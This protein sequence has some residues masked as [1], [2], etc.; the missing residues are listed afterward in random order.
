MD[1]IRSFRPTR[2]LLA[3]F[4]KKEEEAAEYEP[5]TADTSFINDPSTDLDDSTEPTF[6]W[7]EY[8]IF[9]LL[10]VAM[11]WAWNMFLAAQP[12]FQ[13][14][15]QADPWVQDN[16]MSAILT[17]STFT[18][19]GAM[20]ILSNIQYSASYPFRINLALYINVAAFALLALSTRIFLDLA[21]AAYLTFILI[22][23]GSTAY[24]AGLIQNGA[25][26]FAASF[27]RSE[28]T[29]AIMAGQ[30][31][32]GVLPP[33]VQVISVLVAPPADTS[34]HASAAD[35]DEGKAAFLY[36][37][38]AVV[39]SLVALVAFVPLVRRHDQLVEN[40]MAEHMAASMNSIEEAE[41][42]ARKVVSMTTLFK[43]LH[44][45][46]GAVF[47]C[48]VVAMFFPVLTPKV[49]SVVPSEDAPTLLKP[50][51]FIPLAFFFW[52]LGDL[53]GRSAALVLPL[54]D[55]PAVL[56]VFSIARFLF[57]PLYALC[58]LNG[59]GAAI[60]SDAF[61]LLLVQFPYGLTNGWLASNCM[62]ASSEWVE[63]GEREAAG[64]FMG[65]CL[66]AGLAAGSMLSFTVAGV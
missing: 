43:K 7:I 64:G 16:F 59:K 49:L 62:M 41:R 45:L 18:N 14:R 31:V 22:I 19:L 27:G 30:G 33:L 6:S 54:R 37:V 55:R 50:Y 26:A 52:N 36:F 20:V 65:M 35:N 21:P 42:A 2:D 60:S 4:S 32:A 58:N 40:R 15:F 29:Q 9:A 8:G 44:W 46:A 25:F 3:F 57:L 34:T 24:A 61:F 51:A 53:S 23:V 10:G 63:E 17:V 13:A 5:L 12:Y 38:T 48:F 28:Y 56:F 1:R 66:V 11:L 47:M 39:V